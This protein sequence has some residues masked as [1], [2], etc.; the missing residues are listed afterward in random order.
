[1]PQKTPAMARLERSAAQ[2]REELRR[3]YGEVGLAAVATA[4]NLELEPETIAHAQGED[5]HI[6]AA[7]EDQSCAA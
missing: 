3:F 4:L 5:D 1:M 6:S 7:L 2:A